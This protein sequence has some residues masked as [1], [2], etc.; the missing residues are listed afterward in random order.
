MTKTEAKWAERISEWRA[1]G[2]TADAFAEGKGFK[3]GTLRW[4]STRLSRATSSAP[5]IPFARVVR[6]PRA[7]SDAPVVIAVGVARVEV[8]RGFDPMLLREVVAALGGAP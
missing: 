6:A 5:A 8:A 7:A 4:W 3:A 1:S 2:Q